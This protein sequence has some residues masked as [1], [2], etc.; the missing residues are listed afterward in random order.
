MESFRT[1][2]YSSCCP[3]NKTYFSI[4][5]VTIEARK[6]FAVLKNDSDQTP[7]VNEYEKRVLSLPSGVPA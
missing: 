2:A 1:G 7:V 3:V 5:F 4:F 6:G